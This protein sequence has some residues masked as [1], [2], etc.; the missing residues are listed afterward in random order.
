MDPGSVL[1]LPG[2]TITWFLVATAFQQQAQKDNNDRNSGLHNTLS[3]IILL[4][5]G[6]A[7]RKL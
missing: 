2:S 7:S 5:R 6:I 3:H 4:L 1:P